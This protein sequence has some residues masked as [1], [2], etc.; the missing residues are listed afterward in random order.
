M[1]IVAHTDN[2]DRKYNFDA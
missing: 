1:N 2:W